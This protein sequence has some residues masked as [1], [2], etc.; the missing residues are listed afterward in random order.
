MS[1][2]IAIVGAG[3]IGFAAAGA[4]LDAGWNVRVLAR[5]EPEWTAGD[6]AFERYIAGEDAAPAADVVL[7]TIAYD[8]EDIARYDPAAI[9]RLIVVSS[10]SVYCDAKGRTL[11]EGLANGYPQFDGPITED[12]T[13]VAPGPATYS[14]RKIR[15]EEAARVRFGERATILRPCAVYGPHSRHPR[16]L[17]FVKRIMDGRKQIPLAD[18]G[19]SQFQTSS[20]RVIARTALAAATQDKGGV[21]NVAD[22]DSPT[23]REIGE[24]IAK[25]LASDVTMIPLREAGMIGRTPWSVPE[26]FVVDARQAQLLR[27][28]GETYDYAEQVGPAALWLTER[29]LANWRAAFPQLAEYPWDLFDYDAED[30]F[31]ESL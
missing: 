17:W 29:D 22:C 14:T 5:S 15:M 31:F 26:P 21:F 4:F 18:A 28:D 9:G 24:T 2:T 19:D 30:R 3:Q 1:K 23:V 8:A 27:A 6:G 13:T 10:A 20:A 7:D 16:E 11:D 12:Q 25:S